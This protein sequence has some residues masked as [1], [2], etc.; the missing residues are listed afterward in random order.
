MWYI[1]N[2]MYTERPDCRHARNIPTEIGQVGCWVLSQ[3]HYAPSSSA[4]SASSTWDNMG[5]T[6]VDFRSADDPVSYAEGR[7]EHSQQTKFSSSLPTQAR[8]NELTITDLF[9]YRAHRDSTTFLVATRTGDC[10]VELVLRWIET[11]SSLQCH[12]H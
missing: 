7:G 9:G 4:S 12:Q 2:P 1:D 8:V 6:T 10:L 3:C 5:L 11:C